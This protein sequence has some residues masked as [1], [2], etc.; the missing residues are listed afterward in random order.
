[1]LFIWDRLFGAFTADGA[2]VI[3]KFG[4]ADFNSDASNPIEIA[5]REWRGMLAPRRTPA[6]ELPPGKG[7]NAGWSS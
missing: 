3:H 7:W 1:M 6:N 2:A 4:R 5:T